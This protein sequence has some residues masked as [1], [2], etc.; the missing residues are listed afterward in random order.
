MYLHNSYIATEP[1]TSVRLRALAAQGENRDRFNSAEEIQY[2]AGI[3]PVTERSGQKS[4]VRRRWQYAK[5]VQQTFVVWLR[6][7]LT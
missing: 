1:A 2:Y 7:Q 5:F 6:R 3:A 4:C